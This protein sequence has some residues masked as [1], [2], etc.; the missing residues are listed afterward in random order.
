MINR[1]QK[2]IYIL[3]NPVQLYKQ[4]KLE[5]RITDGA[6]ISFKED[7]AEKTELM[8]WKN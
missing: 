5:M 3:Q 8:I 2:V 7:V 6:E 1:S 4:D